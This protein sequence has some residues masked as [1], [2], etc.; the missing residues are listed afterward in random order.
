MSQ[1]AILNTAEA[2]EIERKE[3]IVKIEGVIDLPTDSNSKELFDGLLE[4]IIEYVE[5]HKGLAGL[6]MEHEDY[7]EEPELEANNGGQ[8]A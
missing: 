4:L 3:H 7:V 5:K 1:Q 8:A 2:E 6:S